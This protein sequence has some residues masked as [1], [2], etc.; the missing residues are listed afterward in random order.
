M[1][2]PW[3]AQLVALA[4]IWGSSFLFIKVLGESW[5]PLWVALGRVGLG[6]LTLCALLAARGERLP[7]GGGI[8]V[9]AAPVAVL[10]NA[11]P[12]VLFAYGEQHVSS[13]VAG[14]WN[15]TVP[16]L[17]LGVALAALP[18]ERPTR[19]RVAGLAIGFVGVA[20]LLAPWHGLGGDELL[21]HLACL[22]A[23]ACYAVGLPLTRR[24]LA[25][26]PESGVALAAAQLLCATAMLAVVAP[27]SPGPALDL[28]LAAIGSLLAL[29]VLGSGVAYILNYAIVRAAGATTASTVTYVIPLFSTGLGVLV[30][31]EALGW[32]E[33]VGALVVLAGIAVS[34]RR[35]PA[36]GARPSWPSP[37]RAARARSRSRSPTGHAARPRRPARRRTPR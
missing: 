10:M 7:R 20:L 4:A 5:P 8:W 23:A 3:Q 25:G 18:D 14:L 33:P 22:G 32:N 16:L 15:A 30:L 35:A 9:R 13:I 26:R 34:Q 19:E 37:R 6:A 28:P 36:P 11:V 2:L 24:T 1:R 29:G 17:V 27:L 31:G 12:F 21:G